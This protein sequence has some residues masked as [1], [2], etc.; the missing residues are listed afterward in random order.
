LLGFYFYCVYVSLEN[1]VFAKVATDADM[2]LHKIIPI[3]IIC[4]CF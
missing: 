2:A 4:L 1:S 3:L